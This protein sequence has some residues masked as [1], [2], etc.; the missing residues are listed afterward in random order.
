MTSQNRPALGAAFV[1]EA[2]RRLTACHEQI[3]HCLEQLDDAQVWWRPQPEMNSIANLVLHLC[4]NLGQWIIA[5]VGG[6]PDTRQRPQEFAERGPILRDELMQRLDTV[7]R[8][9]DAVL[10]NAA[11]SLL[12]QPR[13]IQGFDETVLSAIFACLVHLGGHTQEIVHLTRVQ[14]GGAYRFAWTPKTVEQGALLEDVPAAEVIAARDAIF[15]EGLASA[16]NPG[17]PVT[18]PTTVRVPSHGPGSPLVDPLRELQ[19]EF[20]DQEREGKL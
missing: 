7:I 12:L 18:E 11:E 4:G 16:I 17:N 1:V 9:A 2:R 15:G 8:E 6:A 19:Q 5:G 13:R 10:G 3:R 20:Q 14:L